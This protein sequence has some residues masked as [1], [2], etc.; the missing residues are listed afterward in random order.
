MSRIDFDLSALYNAIDARRQERQMTWSAVAQEINRYKTTLRPISLSTIKGLQH[1]AVGEGDGILQMLLWLGR[2]PES[3][4]R[5]EITADRE[6][7]L[8]PNVTHEQILRWDTRLLF[9]A[10]N[11]QRQKK[12]LTWSQVSAEIGGW[13]PSM[14]TNLAKGGRTGFPRVMR[15]VRWLGQPAATFT[16]ISFW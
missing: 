7:F 14:L 4:G 9:R 10:V 8:L 12:Q 11:D 16:R 5:N 2:S 6:P 15:V 3:F 13:T 1:K